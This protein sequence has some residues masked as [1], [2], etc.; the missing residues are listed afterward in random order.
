[1]GMKELMIEAKNNNMSESF[2]LVDDSSMLLTDDDISG[3]MSQIDLN[4]VK[5]P[6]HLAANPAF[7][8]LLDELG[9]SS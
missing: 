3:T 4:A 5:T 8:F 9:Q 2:M 7:Q 1:M 6:E